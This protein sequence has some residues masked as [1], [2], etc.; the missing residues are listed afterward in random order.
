[1]GKAG[2]WRRII[3]DWRL[4]KDE[5]RWAIDDLSSSIQRSEITVD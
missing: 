3:V 4:M 1:M 5:G 2:G